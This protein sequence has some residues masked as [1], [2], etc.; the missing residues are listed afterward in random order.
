[1]RRILAAM[2]VTRIAA[3]QAPTPADVAFERGRTLLAA[4]KYDDACA[5]FDESLRLDFQFGTLFNAADCNQRRGHLATAL[6]QWKRIAADDHNTGRAVKAHDNAAA[7]EPRVPKLAITVV[8]PVARMAITIDGTPVG[9][10]AQPLLVDLGSHEIVVTAPGL[11]DSR[12]NVQVT[13]EANVVRVEVTTGKPLSAPE[14]ASDVSAPL[15]PAE[16]HSRRVPAGK[17]LF[18]TGIATVAAGLVVGGIAYSDWSSAQDDAKTNVGKANTG[19]DHVRLLGNV[20]TGLVAGGLVIGAVGAYL[21][22]SGSSNVRT[23]ASVGTS[24]ASVAVLVSF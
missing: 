22:H 18:V 4:G 24:H 14:G 20:S 1:M 23:T 8:H 21:W 7:L 15:P 2:L 12:R 19:V 9:D 16:E 13:Q 6:A 5:A 10:P 11:Q 3:A 17:A